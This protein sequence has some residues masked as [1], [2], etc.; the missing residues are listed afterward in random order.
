MEESSKDWV[1]S[2]NQDVTK[3]WETITNTDKSCM[4]AAHCEGKGG[5][6]FKESPVLERWQ[7]IGVRASMWIRIS[8]S[9]A[10]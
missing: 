4:N 2:E 1:C 8:G 6:R 10:E 9:F 7:E 5:L 3:K